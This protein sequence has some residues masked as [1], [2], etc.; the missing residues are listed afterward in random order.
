VI[1][2]E[3]MRTAVFYSIS[4]AQPGL[5]GVSFGNFLIKQVVEDLKREMPQLE[6]FVTLSPVPGFAAWAS[7]AAHNP[8][9][10]A[11]PGFN[12]E[13]VARLQARDWGDDEALAKS[14]EALLLPLAAR[15]F[16]VAKDRKGRVVDPVARFHLGNGARLERLNLRG[17]L[18][19]KGLAQSFGLMVN[20]LYDPKSIESNHEAYATRGEVIASA[21]IRKNL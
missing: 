1:A 5:A 10:L 16:L 20:Y 9:S 13:A 21:A 6:T 2:P 15:Y 18:S 14:L 3:R 11:L 19:P 17:D 7:K 12:A 4:N 8:E